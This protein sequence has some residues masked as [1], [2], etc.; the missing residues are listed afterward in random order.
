VLLDGTV[1]QNN[2]PVETNNTWVD[3]SQFPTGISFILV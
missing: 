2:L 3:L 1:L